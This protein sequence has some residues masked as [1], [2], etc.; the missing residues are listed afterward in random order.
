MRASWPIAVPEAQRTHNSRHP[1]YAHTQ[2]TGGHQLHSFSY[3]DPSEATVEPRPRTT[4]P[5]SGPI[6]GH[7]IDT[8]S[9]YKINV[10]FNIRGWRLTN[11]RIE[12]VEKSKRS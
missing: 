4:A 9:N 11:N 8:A 1:A 7:C 6:P 12:V 10:T 2:P 3:T 5:D